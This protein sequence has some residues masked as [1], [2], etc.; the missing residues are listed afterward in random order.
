MPSAQLWLLAASTSLP[1]L[2]RGT[3]T[4]TDTGDCNRFTWATRALAD[5]CQG[6]I[7]TFTQSEQN[8]G[9]ACRQDNHLS[10]VIPLVA[11]SRADWMQCF[12]C[13]L[14]GQRAIYPTLAGVTPMTSKSIV[15]TQAWGVKGVSPVQTE[16]TSKDGGFLHTLRD[17][18]KF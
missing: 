13:L 7:N 18:L 9:P 1:G 15:V 2:C 16:G 10:T 8:K 5:H 12:I 11:P 17:W 3:H 6:R 14:R 4:R